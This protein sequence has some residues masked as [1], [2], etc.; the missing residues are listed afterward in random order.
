MD[1]F[2]NL[3]LNVPRCAARTEQDGNKE[4]NEAFHRLFWLKVCILF[5]CIKAGASLVGKDVMAHDEDARVFL[6]QHGH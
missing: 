2:R 4:E 3:H 6:F 5:G 1:V